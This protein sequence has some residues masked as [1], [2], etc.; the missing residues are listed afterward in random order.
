VA[1]VE[2]K[3]RSGLH[4]ENFTHFEVVSFFWKTYHFEVGEVFRV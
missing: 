4:T 2:T 3:P 1:I